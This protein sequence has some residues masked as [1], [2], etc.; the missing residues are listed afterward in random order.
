MAQAIMKEAEVGV[1]GKVLLS[2]VPTHS[3][4]VADG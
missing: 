1:W 4:L 3:K 2:Q